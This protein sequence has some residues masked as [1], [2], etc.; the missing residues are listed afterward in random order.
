MGNRDVRPHAWRWASPWLSYLLPAVDTRMK[1]QWESYT[2]SWHT[3]IMYCYFLTSHL[4]AVTPGAW[5]VWISE[6]LH[7]FHTT[8]VVA[9][10]SSRSLE[11]AVVQGTRRNFMKCKLSNLNHLKQKNKN[12]FKGKKQGM[13]N[14]KFQ[15]WKWLLNSSRFSLLVKLW[16]ENFSD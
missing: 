7:S 12:F 6:P 10:A 11:H 16:S 1:L 4:Q 9:T 3:R 14:N 2:W 8:R 5:S 13:E 15:S